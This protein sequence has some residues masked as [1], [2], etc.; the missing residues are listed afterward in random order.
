[1]AMTEMI[2]TKKIMMMMSNNDDDG[3]TAM[4]FFNR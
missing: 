3:D 1:M 2:K 4:S